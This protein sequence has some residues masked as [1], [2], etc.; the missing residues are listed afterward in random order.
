MQLTLE[1]KVADLEALVRALLGRDN[2]CVADKRVVNTRVGH[3]VGLELVQ[4][5]VEGTVES[6]GRGDGADDL[7]DQTVE[8]LVVGPGNIQA[9]TAD[10]VDRLVVDEECAVGVLDGAVSREDRVVGLDDGGRDARS[11]VNGELELALLAV[12]GG[13][14][15]EEESTETRTCTSAKR[16]EDQ[17]ALE[18]RAVVCQSSV[19]LVVVG[20]HVTYRRHGESCQ[21]RRRPSPCR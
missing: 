1:G 17:E 14:A 5:N 9:A 19:Q 18:R 2:G 21:S 16:V 6:Q 7:G 12:I 4:I 3:E 11:R 10:V 13:E 15:L 20:V 8:M